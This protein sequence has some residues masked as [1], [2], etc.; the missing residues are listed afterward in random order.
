MLYGMVLIYVCVLCCMLFDVVCFLSV[1]L[2]FSDVLNI[3]YVYFFTVCVVRLG[4]FVPKS[5]R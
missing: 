1:F 4:S 3:F 2:S 5:Y